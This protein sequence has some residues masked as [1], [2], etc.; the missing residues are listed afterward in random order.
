MLSF[1][2]ITLH[3]WS[4]T[5]RKLSFYMVDGGESLA[6]QFL[7]GGDHPAYRRIRNAYL[8][9]ITDLIGGGTLFDGPGD[10]VSQINRLMKGEEE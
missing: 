4:K 8:P 3:Y 7:V 6:V 5:S 1:T 10:A 9:E 2:R